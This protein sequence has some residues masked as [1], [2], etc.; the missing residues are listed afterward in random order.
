MTTTFLA[1]LPFLSWPVA[2]GGLLRVGLVTVLLVVTAAGVFAAPG[3]VAAQ[4]E[5]HTNS[6]LG[7]TVLEDC[8]SLTSW[9]ARCECRHCIRSLMVAQY[10]DFPLKPGRSHDIDDRMSN[11]DVPRYDR[12]RMETQHGMCSRLD[13]LDAT[14]GIVRGL[15]LAL[16]GI[17]GI[18]FV[19][20][21]VQYMQES[22]VG[23]QVV[24][25][26]SNIFRIVV[27]LMIFG[28][29]WLIYESLIVALFGTSDFSP[30]SYAGVGGLFYVGIPE[31]FQ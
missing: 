8:A 22:V 6:P 31:G 3:T 30:G 21:V 15:A 12:W 4:D 29:A 9:E 23:G 10:F 18:S 1:A 7:A 25:A 20:A 16:T 13:L 17:A 14:K 5:C 27:G 2:K 24:Q 26:R 28:S 19:W 11:Y